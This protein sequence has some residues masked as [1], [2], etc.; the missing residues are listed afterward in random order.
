MHHEDCDVTQEDFVT[1]IGCDEERV[2]KN[3]WLSGQCSEV[4]RG[5]I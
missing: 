1:G 5:T 3:F 2:K 4:H